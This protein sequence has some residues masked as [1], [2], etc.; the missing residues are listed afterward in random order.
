MRFKVSGLFDPKI[1][2]VNVWPDLTNE[3]LFEKEKAITKLPS[4]L[5]VSYTTH[6]A[7]FIT[8]LESFGFVRE[9]DVPIASSDRY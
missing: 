5:F 9:K 7:P 4:R 8:R 6:Y 3:N 2:L 1:D